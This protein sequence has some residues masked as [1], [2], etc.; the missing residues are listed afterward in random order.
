MKTSFRFPV[1]IMVAAIVLLTPSCKKTVTVTPTISSTP[2]YAL[3]I[4]D[5][6]LSVFNAAV[7]KAGDSALFHGI[8]SI[9]VLAP[10]NAALLAVSILAL[11]RPDLRQKLH[12][13][14][15]DQTAKVMA[16]NTLGEKKA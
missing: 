7:Q 8:D 9:T 5:T 15:A 10:T 12:Q 1:L 3:L 11:S 2:L 6:S 13:F 4:G 16:D 14:R